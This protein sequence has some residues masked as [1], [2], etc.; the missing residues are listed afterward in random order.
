M[1]LQAMTELQ[2]RVFLYREQLK[3]KRDS[4]KV[5]FVIEPLSI[6]PLSSYWLDLADDFVTRNGLAAIGSGW[7]PLTDTEIVEVVTY[8]LREDMAYHSVIM[9]SEEATKMATDFM[10]FFEE[11]HYCLTNGT[12]HLPPRHIN[13]RV[14]QGAS[15]TPLTK[16]TF[17]AGVVIM[18]NTKIGFLVVMDED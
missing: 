18:D 5:L 2:E 17:D 15:W 13:G 12:F 7:I 4:G 6:P 10:D 14:I 11:Q 3:L 1:R 9:T 16:A 8:I